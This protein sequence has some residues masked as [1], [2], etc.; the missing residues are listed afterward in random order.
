V[1]WD[2]VF[3]LEREGSAYDLTT[4]FESAQ[5]MQDDMSDRISLKRAFGSLTACFGAFPAYYRTLFWPGSVE[6][7][8]TPLA[9]ASSGKP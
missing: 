3:Y 6:I 8:N 2:F 1:A 4:P 7:F 5:G 9:N